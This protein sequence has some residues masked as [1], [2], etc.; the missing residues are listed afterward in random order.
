MPYIRKRKFI[1]KR[2]YYRRFNKRRRFLRKRA[3][4]YKKPETKFYDA[5]LSSTTIDYASPSF[6]LLND[7][8]QGTSDTDVIGRNYVIKSIYIRLS[9]YMNTGTS[10]TQ[11]RCMLVQDKECNGTAIT[12]SQLWTSGAGVAAII[13]PVNQLYVNRFRILWDK[14]Y[15]FSSSGMNNIGIKKFLKLAV[16]VNI[17]GTNS[18]TISDIQHNSIYLIFTSDRT[19]TLLP[20]FTFFYRLRFIDM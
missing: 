6:V 1:K 20:T 11:V 17:N 3:R 14:L 15:S 7:L 12:S 5:S 2:P 9:M 16:K 8:V 19:I 18:G 13:S 10:Q 4:I